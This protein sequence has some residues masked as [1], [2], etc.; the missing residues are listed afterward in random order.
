MKRKF[1]RSGTGHYKR[2]G[3][4]KKQK[5]RK[6]RGHDNKMRLKRKGRLKKVEVGYRTRKKDRGKI[7]GK[8]PVLV[9]NLKQAKKIAKGQLVIIGKMGKK[10]RGQI[11]NRVK[12]KGG[13]ILNLKKKSKEEK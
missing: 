7:K 12:E 8:I 11:E 6:P 4:K 13:E 2:L 1:L 3:R 5:W 9:R 10:K